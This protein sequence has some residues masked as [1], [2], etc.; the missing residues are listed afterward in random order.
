M[1]KTNVVP[2][3]QEL[4][5]LLKGRLR[6]ADIKEVFAAS[7]EDADRALQLGFQLSELCYVGLLDDRPVTCFGARR[8]SMVSDRGIVWLL[9]TDELVRVKRTFVKQSMGY[10]DILSNA[11]PVLEN[12]V[13]IRNEFSIKWLRW[14]GFQFAEKPEP[15][16]KFKL[17]F[18]HFWLRR[19]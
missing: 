15:F 5:D 19:D 12:W 14:C 7:G 16:G 18:Y 4:V 17:P 13:D 8:T 1:A 2:A 6:E 10:V 3:T 9:G 11:F